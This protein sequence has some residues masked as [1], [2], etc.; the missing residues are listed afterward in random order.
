MCPLDIPHSFVPGTKAK[1]NEV[2]A[3][4]NSIKTFVDANEVNIAQNELSISGLQENKADLNGAIENK[5]QVAD[6]TGNYD[7]VNKQTLSALTANTRDYIGGFKLTKYSDDTITADPGNAW[8]ST[9]TYMFNQPTALQVTQSNLGANATYY[10]YVTGG[11]GINNTLVIS[12]SNATP[13][14]P[15]GAIVFRMLGSFLTDGSS[16]ISQVYSLSNT[17]AMEDTQ[18]SFAYHCPDYNN[19]Q[20]R[21][22]GVTYT[23][24]QDGWIFYSVNCDNNSMSISLDGFEMTI[25][26]ESG[27]SSVTNAGCFP[28]TAGSS[29]AM[30]GNGAVLKL[31]F[32]PIKGGN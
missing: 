23:E 15:S 25:D 16:K 1:A 4:F 17:V 5:F 32:I 28:I 29:W 3:N 6:P 20:S 31:A 18:K 11:E 10:V 24:T 30:W 21:S 22:K 2:N 12:L 14:L 9:Y 7:A 19:P 8:D 13:E 27:R 26:N